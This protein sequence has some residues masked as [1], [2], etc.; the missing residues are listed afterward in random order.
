VTSVA[1]GDRR[2]RRKEQTRERI[3]DAAVELF[4]GQGYDATSVDQIAAAADVARGTFF[5]HFPGKEDVTHA[6]IERRR[7]EIRNTIAAASAPDAA[8]RILEGFKVAAALYDADSAARRPMVRTWI[9]CGGP[10]GPGHGQTAESI[11]TVLDAGQQ[12]GQLRKDLDTRTAALL[13]QDTFLGALCRWAAADTDSLEQ[14][15]QP[16]LDLVMPLL[17]H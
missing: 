11:R 3:V 16:A 6:W 15:L 12:A 10:F 17:R 13:L 7:D 2:A 9:R 14:H 1:S 8:A 5:N 4:I